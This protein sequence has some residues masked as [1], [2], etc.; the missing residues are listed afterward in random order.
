MFSYPLILINFKSYKEALGNRAIELANYARKVQKEFD[1]TVGVA[2]QHVDLRDISRTGVFTFAQ[3][4]DPI[5]PGSY[6]GH[7]T[8]ESLRDAGVTGVIINHSEHRMLL[9]DINFIIKK[10]RQL[11][12]MTVVCADTVET[13][14]AVSAL[15]PDIVA[16][17]P[18]ELIGTGRA[19]SKVNPDIVRNT[20]IGIRSITK[21][22]HILCGAG[23]TNGDD[24]YAAIRLGTEGVLLASGVVK[25]EDP[26]KV[27]TEMAIAAKKA[28]EE[29]H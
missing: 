2:P 10:A 19:V 4:V 3:H 26:Y 6:T 25:A 7:I 28:Y 18:P 13:S 16:I 15:K 17:E 29:K 5:E 20:V 8:L 14:M 12:L 11:G 22:V 24:V 1:V 23:I 21:D 27:L 9:S